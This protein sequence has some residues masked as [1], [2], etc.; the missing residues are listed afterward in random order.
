M[1]ALLVV[2]NRLPVRRQIGPT[3]RAEWEPSP[4]G[5]ASALSTALAHREATWIGWSGDGDGGPPFDHR[6]TTLR[7]IG[8]SPGELAGFYEGFSNRTLWPLFH[9]AIRPPELD[10][11]WWSTYVAVN[12]RYAEAAADLAG[13]GAVVWV[14][15]YQLQLVPG[16]LR[17]RRPD[18]RIGFFLHIPYPP[19]ELFMRLP[20]RRQLVEGLLGADVVGFQVPVA[21]RNFAVLARRL[22]GA[23]G[24]YP[25][26]VFDG[27]PVRVGAYPISVDVDWFERLAATAEAETSARGVRE[28]L[29]WPRVVLLGVDRLD[30]TKGI[31]ARLAAYGDLLAAGR[32]SVPDCVM[33]QVA[34]PSRGGIPAYRDERANLAHQ[35]QT[36][37]GRF[38]RKGI[39]AVHYLEES[40]E[41]H[42]LV[43]LYRAADVLVVTPYRDGMNLVVKE[44]VSCRLDGDGA[45][46]LSEFAG[47]ARQLTGATLVN[48]YD[49]DQLVAAI[50]SVVAAPEDERR[51]RM[52]RLRRAVRAWTAHDWSET[53]LADL[54]RFGSNRPR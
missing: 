25:D 13:R 18:L 20:W 38:G 39:P 1:S 8:L 27:R 49:H 12:R 43:G 21:A 35:V 7:P 4:G 47:A 16:M 23:T 5:L 10:P 17:A 19:Q 33:V 31:G 51:R 48:P 14:H 50:G 52:R 45:V 53:F 24:R 42:Q 3:G 6:G 40:L 11:T 29:G 44:F 9:D 28:R 37:N 30:Y 2:A 54:D 46:V 26:L 34:A 36:L 22:A 32:L 41:V 15:D